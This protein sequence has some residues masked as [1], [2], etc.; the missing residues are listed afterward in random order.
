MKSQ[1]AGVPGIG[2]TGENSSGVKSLKE[3]IAGGVAQ[4]CTFS[5]VDESGSSEG[6]TYVAGGK[7]RGDFTTT[8]SG[9]TTASHMIVDGNTN[10]IWMDGEKTG[11]KTTIEET[12]ETGD[13]PVTQDVGS[14]GGVSLDQRTDYKCSAWITDLSQFTPP[15]TVQ[16]TDLS[17]I[18]NPS[19]LPVSYP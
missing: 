13:T 4:R 11:F 6:T 9:K 19:S 3:L 1:K 7:M 15:A 14:Q 16:F 17:Q 12:A 18:F 2:S 8:S 10:Y 5:T